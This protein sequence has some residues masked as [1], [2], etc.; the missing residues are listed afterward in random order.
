MN[1]LQEIKNT[2][3]RRGDLKFLL[4]PE[5][6]DMYTFYWDQHQRL[7]VWNCSR[8]LGKSTSLT[9]VAL[10]QCLKTPN[11]LVIFAAPTAKQAGEILKQKLIFLLESCPKDVK[12][13]VNKSAGEVEFQNGSRMIVV[14]VDSDDGRRLRGNTAHMILLDEAAFMGD[15]EDLVNNIFTPMTR[16]TNGR[17]IISSTP[18]HTMAHAFPEY[19][20]RAK[21]NKGYLQKTIMQSGLPLNEIKAAIREHSIFNPQGKIIKYGNKRP[22]FRIEYMCELITDE[23]KLIIPEWPS[24]KEFTVMDTDR[25]DSFQ[26]YVGADWGMRDYDAII[27][28][29]LD[30]A[31]QK[32]VIEDEILENNMT[33]SD[34]GALI[35]AKTEKLYPRFVARQEITTKYNDI[36]FF[37]DNDLRVISEIRKQTGITFMPA[38]KYDRD[39]SITSLRTTIKS[40]KIE[41]NP[42]CTNLIKQLDEGIWEFNKKGE[43]TDFVRN[44]RLGHCDALSA[45]RYL[46][47]MVKWDINPIKTPLPSEHDHH[48]TPQ[49][50][51]KHA[52]PDGW[53]GI[54][55]RR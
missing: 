4:R 40:C 19:V 44:E 55:G 34:I 29:Y 31:R 24:V 3:W 10:A 15:L 16:Q 13:K 1:K 14:G 35:K 11:S 5:Q 48:I 36:K 38:A 18:P 43:R 51:K 52:D 46:H 17:I 28:G 45:F 47:R 21:H 50:R 6:K 39:A 8:Q 2:L 33:P 49:V 53:Q 23:E 42:R 12:P 9:V 41:I 20:G 32:L 7:Q 26:P 54:I 25:P 30:F 37:S 27:F 22:G